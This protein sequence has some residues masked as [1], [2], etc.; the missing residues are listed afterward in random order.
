LPIPPTLQ[1]APVPKEHKPRNMLEDNTCQSVKCVGNGA[2]CSSSVDDD[3]FY[4][5]SESSQLCATTT[6]NPNFLCYNQIPANQACTPGIV[7]ECTYNY[8]CISG[9]CQLVPYLA[10]GYKCTSDNQ[11]YQVDSLA[12]PIASTCVNGLCSAL[13]LG[14]TCDSGTQCGPFAGCVQGVCTAPLSL[15]DECDTASDNC[16]GTTFCYTSDDTTTDGICTQ[17]YSIPVGSFCTTDQIFGCTEGNY[18]DSTT[19]ECTTPGP[20]TH[21]NCTSG[22]DCENFQSCYCNLNAGYSSCQT[23]AP[24]IVPVGA[25]STANNYYSCFQKNLCGD[26]DCYFQNC[27]NEYCQFAKDLNVISYYQSQPSCLLD[28]ASYRLLQTCLGSGASF[29]VVNLTV[30]IFGC[31]AVMLLV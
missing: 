23:Y 3:P 12:N 21:A 27:K 11:C 18:C 13:A 16:G 9:T 26:D 15:G 2:S 7:G 10:P 22:A 25:L 17:F 31:L 29:V 30:L 4:A 6:T 20:I 24:Y 19:N 5:C 8:N 28:Y 1:H 14:Q